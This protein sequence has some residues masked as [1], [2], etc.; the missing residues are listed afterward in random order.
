MIYFMKF[1][2]RIKNLQIHRKASK[3]YKTELAGPMWSASTFLRP[4]W[5]ASHIM[6]PQDQRQSWGWTAW[7]EVLP[8]RGR[9]RSH[10]RHRSKHGSAATRR[11]GRGDN[12]DIK[13]ESTVRTNTAEKL[14]AWLNS[15]CGSCQGE[16]PGGTEGDFL[17][18]D[19]RE[20]RCDLRW[21]ADSS[22]EPLIHKPQEFSTQTTQTSSWKS[23][24]TQTDEL[25]DLVDVTFMF[26][27]LCYLP[28]PDLNTTE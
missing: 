19:S 5:P 1:R 14:E 2:W 9:R 4:R 27:S 12:A 10:R 16:I 26:L 23:S 24:R 21:R 6:T 13:T 20:K 22:W 25:R 17:Q 7:A 8:L 18:P 15:C 11:G 3:L 28:G